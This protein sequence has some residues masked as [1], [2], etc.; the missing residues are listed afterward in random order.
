MTAKMREVHRKKKIQ[1]RQSI[2]AATEK[3]TAQRKAKR[4]EERKELEI[5]KKE[6]HAKHA[7]RK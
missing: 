6:M 4:E 5:M 2:Q 3:M 1:E 7:I